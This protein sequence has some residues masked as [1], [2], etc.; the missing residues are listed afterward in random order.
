MILAPRLEKAWGKEKILHVYLNEIYL[1]EG[2]YGVEAAARSYFDK[3][4]EHLS[5]AESAMIAGLVSSPARYNPFKSQELA[6]HRQLVVL[7]RMLRFGFITQEEY[8]KAKGQ[9]L[10][11]KREAS[12]FARFGS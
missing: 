10:I 5:V 1:G 4:V 2:C 3:P 9:Q 7:D 6:R 11:T 12:T 8:E